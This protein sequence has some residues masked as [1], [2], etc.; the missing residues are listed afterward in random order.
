MR[1]IEWFSAQ[2]EDESH[3]ALIV[4]NAKIKLSAPAFLRKEA[5]K[6]EGGTAEYESKVPPT[7]RIPVSSKDRFNVE[8]H[9]NLLAADLAAGTTFESYYEQ[10]RKAIWHSCRKLWGS[11]KTYSLYTMR[12]QYS[13]NQRAAVGSTKTSVLMGHSRPDTPSASYYGKAN[14]AHAGFRE[15]RGEAGQQQTDMPTHTDAQAQGLPQE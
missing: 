6:E 1:P 13:A 14:Q 9:M 4:D 8:T 2:W 10:S 12:G 15:L 7:R 5:Q 3:T 11:K